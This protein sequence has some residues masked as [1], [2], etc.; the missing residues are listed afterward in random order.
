MH[1]IYDL[2]ETLCRDLEEYGMKDKLDMSELEVVD[3]LA[4]AIKNIDR[5]IEVYEEREYEGVDNG[6]YPYE[7]SRM[8]YPWNIMNRGGSYTDG[9]GGNYSRYSRGRNSYERSYR[10]SRNDGYS[11]AEEDMDAMINELKDM[12][13]DLPSEKQREV[14][15]FIQRVE[16]M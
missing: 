9:R 10:R 15:K 4:H 2:K 11:R 1:K 13:R 14:Q 6:R 5:I 7:A 12:M 3:T 8:A 16:Q